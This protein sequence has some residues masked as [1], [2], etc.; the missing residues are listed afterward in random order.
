VS[1]A[2]REREWTRQAERRASAASSATA[3]DEILRAL[4]NGDSESLARAVRIRAGAAL[5]DHDYL[6]YWV[7]ELG[8][9]TAWR[10]LG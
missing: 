8:L 4:L 10:A 2:A 3:E 6:A 7:D 1:D 5:L 9:Q